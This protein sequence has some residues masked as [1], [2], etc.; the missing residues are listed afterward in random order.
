MLRKISSKRLA[1]GERLAWNSTIKSKSYTLKKTPLR[2]VSKKSANL[3]VKAR[4]ECLKIWGNKC[5]LCGAENC[6]IHIHHWEETRSQNPARKYD[7]TNLIP[8][9]RCCHC[10]NGVDTKFYELKEKIKN[11]LKYIK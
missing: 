6:E 2:K 10:H 9:C 8:L 3:W 1:K 5:F 4:E 11:K 7:Q